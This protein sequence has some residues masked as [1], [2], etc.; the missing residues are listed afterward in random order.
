VPLDNNVSGATTI[1]RSKSRRGAEVAATLYTVLETAKVHGI[2]PGAYVA[3]AVLAAD[4]GE[5]LPWQF[6]AR[7]S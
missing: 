7:P 1:S 6:Q 2:D 5:A 3:A 4:R